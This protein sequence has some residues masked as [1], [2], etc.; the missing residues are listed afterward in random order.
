MYVRFATLSW[1][2]I[3][4]QKND[5]TP[6]LR[7]IK[8]IPFVGESF[9]AASIYTV[10]AIRKEAEFSSCADDLTKAQ[11]ETELLTELSDKELQGAAGGFFFVQPLV[12]T[13]K[14]AA[15]PFGTPTAISCWQR[16]NQKNQLQVVL[17]Q[18]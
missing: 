1:L 7:R 11:S 6:S 18:Q 15:I 5:R 8:V 2:L 4:N 3:P 9:T 12:G 14:A 16:K 17:I 13:F 10:A